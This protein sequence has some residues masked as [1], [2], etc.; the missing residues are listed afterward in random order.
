MEGA[1]LSQPGPAT[2][3]AQELLVTGVARL[4]QSLVTPRAVITTETRRC[5]QS[6]RGPGSGAGELERA[7]GLPK[8]QCAHKEP[9]GCGGGPSSW[10]I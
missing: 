6:T 4:G 9:C 1:Q 3:G 2:I 8:G 5:P 10:P 7:A